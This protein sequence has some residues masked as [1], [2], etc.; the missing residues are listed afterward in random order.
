[1][2]NTFEMSTNMSIVLLGSFRY[3]KPLI[4]LAE[5]GQ[6]GEVLRFEAVLGGANSQSLDT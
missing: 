5:P 3:L 2:S 1:M 4:T 6:G